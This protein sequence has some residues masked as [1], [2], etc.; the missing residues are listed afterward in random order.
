MPKQGNAPR[1]PAGGRTEPDNVFLRDGEDLPEGR[2]RAPRASGF[3][4]HDEFD[5]PLPSARRA[6]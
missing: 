6:G 2:P 3:R 1:P 4:R 5:V